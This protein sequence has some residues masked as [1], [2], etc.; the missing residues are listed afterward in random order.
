MLGRYAGFLGCTVWFAWSR[1]WVW[2]AWV[3][4]RAWEE[5]RDAI[6]EYVFC[7]SAFVLF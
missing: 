3:V 1:G 7:C 5:W 2:E 6:G 4:W